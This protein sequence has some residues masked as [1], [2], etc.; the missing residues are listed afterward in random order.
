MKGASVWDCSLVELE[1]H[2]S[3]RRGNIS[4]VENGITLPFDIRRVYYLYDV[5]AG[6]SRGGHAHRNDRRLVVAATG[7]FEVTLDDGV[8]RRTVRLNR[9]YSGVLVREGIWLTLSDFSAGAVC[10][11]LAAEPYSEDDYIRDYDSF[12]EYKNGEGKIS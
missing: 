3:D 9:P 11:V 10:L 6:E 7:S 2:H 12:M 4:V 5:P 8:T 1:R